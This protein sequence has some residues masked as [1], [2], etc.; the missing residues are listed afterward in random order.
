[1]TFFLSIIGVLVKILGFGGTGFLSGILGFITARNSEDTKKQTLYM[2]ALQHAISA[3]V[4]ARKVASSERVA[5]WGSAWY[6]LL[7]FMII[8]PPALYIGSVFLVTIF[9]LPYTIS[10]VPTRFEDWGFGLLMTFIGGGS[11]VAA[12]VGAAKALRK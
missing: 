2:T 9:S 10:A 4:E 12:T 11:F 1:M 5:L 8:A 3:E 7:V 6:R